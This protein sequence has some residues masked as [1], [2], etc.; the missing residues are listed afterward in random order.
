MGRWPHGA[1]GP[2]W[3]HVR[4]T[5]ALQWVRGYLEASC[6]SRPQAA[7][8]Q[9]VSMGSC[10]AMRWLARARVASPHHLSL[11]AILMCWSWCCR[12]PQGAQQPGGGGGA[13]RRPRDPQGGEESGRRILQDQHGQGHRRRTRAARR[14]LHLRLCAGGSRCCS[15]GREPVGGGHSLACV[16]SG[17]AAQRCRSVHERGS[18]GRRSGSR[19]AVE[20]GSSKVDGQGRTRSGGGG[21]D[22]DGG[23]GATQQHKRCQAGAGGV[24]GGAY[25]AGCGEVRKALWK[26]AAWGRFARQSWEAVASQ[27]PSNLGAAVRFFSV[28]RIARSRLCLCLCL[29]GQKVMGQ[30]LYSSMMSGIGAIGIATSVC[31]CVWC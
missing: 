21:R 19:A 10:G 4:G 11:L 22:R 15:R 7:G 27:L 16:Y 18:S 28:L 8:C 9:N 6:P 26:S 2:W 12:A 24:A 5:V 17:N 1:F 3:S 13:S 29:V 30:F 25:S 31:E 23:G 14:C 20:A